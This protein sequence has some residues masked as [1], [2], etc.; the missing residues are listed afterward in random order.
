MIKFNFFLISYKHKAE[1]F[2][3][4]SLPD[5]RLFKSL[6]VITLCLLFFSSD[7]FGRDEQAEE[8]WRFIQS[9]AEILWNV[10]SG[11]D[12]A[13]SRQLWEVIHNLKQFVQHYPESRH[14]PEAYYLLGIA[15]YRVGY[16]PEAEAH[17]LITARYY[18]ETS[19]AGDA[20]N[21]LSRFLEETGNTR[22]LEAF[23]R[24]LV[25]SFPKSHTALVMEAVLGI[26]ELNKGRIDMAEAVV[27]D[28]EK[29]KKNAGVT[30]PRLL[31]LK[32]R[33]AEHKGDDVEARKLWLHYLNL[34]KN[35]EIR[36]D[37]LYRIAETYRRAGEPL[38]AHKYYALIKR[39]F[40]SLKEA[41]FARFRMA[42]IEE[43]AR[44]RMEGYVS[45]MGY[46]NLTGIDHLYTGIIRKYP[47][48]P[49]TME[50][51]AELIGIKL[52]ENRNLQALQLAEEFSRKYA[53]GSR[54]MKRVE[55]MARKAAERLIK[56]TDNIVM[57]KEAVTWCRRFIKKDNNNKI[58]EIASKTGIS[59]WRSLLEMLYKNRDYY[60]LLDSFGDYQKIAGTGDPHVIKASSVA[61][62]GA[63]KLA[64]DLLKSAKYARLLNY[65]YNHR[66]FLDKLDVPGLFIYVGKAWEKA[67]SPGAALDFF[68]REYFLRGEGPEGA[69][70]LVPIA[71]V[72]AQNNLLDQADSAFMIYDKINENS[73]IPPEVSLLKA[74]AAC[75]KGDW[76]A[77]FN[78]SKDAM[79]GNNTAYAAAETAF[80]AAVNLGKWDYVMRIWDKFS[81]GF[82]HKDADLR[83]WGDT[84][85]QL[86][87]PDAAM[88]PYK[89]LVEMD[90]KDRSTEW[91][92]ARAKELKGDFKGADEIRK[93]VAGS[94]ASLWSG[95]AA[96]DNDYSEFMRGPAGEL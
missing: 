6:V 53:N 8:V 11:E 5:V 30:I 9:G 91:K 93:K 33:I 70:A 15:Y 95:A 85:L 3:R 32:A 1:F 29:K 80:M 35:P 2:C 36:A 73:V 19:W 46:R 27:G 34:V 56:D 24:E 43:R 63:S 76:L 78:M 48:H 52:D 62:A 45:G 31:D 66:E 22:K 86:L 26:E 18:P 88:K 89:L 38:E 68:Y 67:G 17:W 60:N 71:A 28:I 10:E 13:N 47:D 16:F 81:K 79:A 69:A 42:E 59:L 41:R 75:K 39:D 44:E 74:E 21:M 51:M 61:R 57:L 12:R 77:A 37:I 7:A 64:E 83:L 14:L 82:K 25:R 72:S 94:P 92:I 65:Y 96:A 54:F 90:P 40:S 87:E 84:A 4:I 49:I 58:E 23:Y 50:V 55:D 20:L